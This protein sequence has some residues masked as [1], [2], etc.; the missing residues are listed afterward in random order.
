MIGDLYA[1]WIDQWEY[2]LATADKNRVVRPFEWGVE[3]L[4]DQPVNGQAKEVVYRLAE[5]AARRSDHFYHFETP[6]DFRLDGNHLTFTSALASPYPENNTVHADFFPVS[7]DRGRAV[8]VLPQWNSDVK[9][10]VGLCKLLNRFGL[11]ALRMSMAYHDRRMPPELQRADYAVSSNIGRTI[12]ASRQSVIDVRSC[13]SWL[14]QQGYRRLGILG[15][16]LGSC[17][18]FIAA[19]HDERIQVGVFNHVSMYFSDVVWTGLSTRHVRQGFEGHVTQDQ[20]RKLWAVISPATYLERLKGRGMKS[21]LVWAKYDTTFLPEYSLQVLES[22][23][24]YRL[25]HEVFTL[26][27]AHYTTGRFPFNWMDGL[28]M[29][30]Y[31]RRHL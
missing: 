7:G 6:R 24:R 17:I 3:W 8:V 13:L 30:R 19:A 23:K 11:T 26:P 14:E 10:H 15:T 18:A 25:P 2:K 1:K 16:S 5:E 22:F 12:H 20:L 9:G 21:L 29:C 28:A 31:L 4:T 27:C